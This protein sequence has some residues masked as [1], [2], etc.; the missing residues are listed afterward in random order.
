MTRQFCAVGIQGQQHVFGEI[1]PVGQSGIKG[2]AGMSFG[3]DKTVAIFPARIV[4]LKIHNSKIKA[5]DNFHQTEGTADVPAARPA[6]DIRHDVAKFLG[7]LIQLFPIFNSVHLHK[8]LLERNSVIF[9]WFTA[10]TQS[11]QRFL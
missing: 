2:R 11:S 8:R 9:I 1:A 7:Q 3:Q 10:E 4:R 5:D 6:H